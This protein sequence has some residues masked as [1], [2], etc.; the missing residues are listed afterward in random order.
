MEQRASWEANQ[1]SASQEIPLILWNTK[2]YY[3]IHKFPPPI[4]ILCQFNPVH[5]PTSHCLK[6]Y[7]NIILPSTPGSS[8][9]SLSLSVSPPKP[10]INLSSPPYVLHAP[11]ISFFLIWP[12]E[13]YWVKSTDHAA[14]HYA[15]SSSPLSTHPS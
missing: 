12:P 9:W 15:A 3:H 4:P 1:I 2:F 7:L 11:P 6:I 10:C 13:Q 5:A 8:K 14:P